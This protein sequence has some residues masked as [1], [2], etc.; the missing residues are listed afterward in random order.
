MLMASVKDALEILD[1][2]SS[3]TIEKEVLVLKE[4]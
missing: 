3:E 4:K 1:Y 2:G